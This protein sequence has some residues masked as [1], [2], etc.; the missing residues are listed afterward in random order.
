MMGP[1]GLVRIFYTV[2]MRY[3]FLGFVLVGS[4]AC[5]SSGKLSM[6]PGYDFHRSPTIAVLPMTD[7]VDLPES[8]RMVTERVARTLTESGL[9][10]STK[11]AVR[12]IQKEQKRLGSK[13]LTGEA[14]QRIGKALG[15]DAVV[16]GRFTARIKREKTTMRSLRGRPVTV[17]RG[18]RLKRVRAPRPLASGNVRVYETDGDVN[19]DFTAR[20]VL[21]TTG[22]VVWSFATE[23][24]RRG[25]QN[26]ADAALQ[27]VLLK[28]SQ[29]I[30]RS[31]KGKPPVADNYAPEPVLKGWRY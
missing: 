15:V 19:F 3:T 10:V 11:T 9:K 30:R 1:K 31:L 13:T 4:L 8:G 5:A 21:V 28:L 26:A 12:E 14:A 29:R 6:R 2:R 7:A 18:G 17:R 23:A 25:F 24:E 27:P 20:M 16:L 22:E